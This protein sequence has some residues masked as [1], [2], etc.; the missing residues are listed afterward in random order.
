MENDGERTQ[1]RSDNPDDKE[2]DLGEKAAPSDCEP[3]TA[4]ECENTVAQT[5]A[6]G[7]A[8]ESGRPHTFLYKSNL[9]LSLIVSIEFN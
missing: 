8:F 2:G 1:V 5:L 7:E 4:A 9:F 6:A 3:N